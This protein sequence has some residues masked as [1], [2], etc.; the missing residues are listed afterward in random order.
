MLRISKYITMGTITIN[1]KDEVENKFRKLA[2][3]LYSGK[4][5]YLGRAVTEAMEIWIKEKKQKEMAERELRVLD[6][7][8]NLGKVLVKKRKDIYDR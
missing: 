7:G 1:V 2:S 5:G 3:A 8:F 4:K 6:K